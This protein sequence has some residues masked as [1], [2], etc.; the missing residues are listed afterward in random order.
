MGT[1]RRT[2]EGRIQGLNEYGEGWLNDGKTTVKAGRTCPGDLVL[3]EYADSGKHF[4]RADR[5]ELREASAKRCPPDCAAFDSGCGGCQWLH[6][7]YAVQAAEKTRVV[8]DFINR[9][10]GLKVAVAPIATMAEP[11]AF[12]NKMSL[13]NVDG[14]PC[15]LKEYSTEGLVPE[16]CRVET[17]ANQ[18]AWAVLRTLELPPEVLQVHLRS[19][20]DAV[21]ICL[22]VKRLTHKARA[23]GES[24]MT[25]IPGAAGVGAAG[26]RDYELLAGA[27]AIEKNVGGIRYRIPHHG[28]FQ[29][30]YAQA[31]TLRALAMEGLKLGAGDRVLDLYCGAGFFSLAAAKLAARVIGVEGNGA[32]VQA[33]KD[34]ANLNGL[35]N[36]RFVASDVGKSLSAFKTGDF[37]H[38]LLDPPRDG[39][40]PAVVQGLLRLCP[41][42]IV[43]VSCSAETLAR[44]LR[45][46][47]AGGY[48]LDSCRPVDMFPHTAHVEVVAVLSR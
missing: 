16:T 27:D 22:F 10:A 24:L 9:R 1:P 12:R 13:T 7:D 38:V 23:F 35:H 4:I 36:L 18:R 21:G 32:S 30:N 15:F 45:L 29:T 31:E 8:A 40:A 43:Y 3:L 5:V 37:S 42:R 17:K 48:R 6:V 39:C 41:A 20:G 26:Y 46:L 47:A 28:F 14:K 25:L 2:V 34:N 33:A 11:W 44:D 19:S